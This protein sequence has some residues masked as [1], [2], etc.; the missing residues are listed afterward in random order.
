VSELKEEAHKK[1]EEGLALLLF[2][3]WTYNQWHKLS[4]A[5]S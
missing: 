3:A 4:M 5:A 1:K 2:R